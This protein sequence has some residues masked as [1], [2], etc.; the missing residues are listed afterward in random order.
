MPPSSISF[1]ERDV[2]LWTFE[3]LERLSRAN[4]K[5]RALDLREAIGAEKLAPLKPAGGRD[6]VISWIINSQA[7]IVQSV[8]G[9]EVTAADWGL[10]AG[11]GDAEE[12][13]GAE[14]SARQRNELTRSLSKADGAALFEDGTA[15]L[16]DDA[17]VGDEEGEEGEEGEEDAD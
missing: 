16:A 12:D 6:H 2:P 17:D 11:V 10:P 1:N 5:Q 15:E 7:L 8:A 9:L 14:E 13:L 3:Q 4:L